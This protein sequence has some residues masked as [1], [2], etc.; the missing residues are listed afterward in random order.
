MR[1][2]LVEG[3]TRHAQADAGGHR[4]GIVQRRDGLADAAPVLADQVVGGQMHVVEHQVDVRA[5]AQAEGGG[6]VSEIGRHAPGVR[7]YR[8][9]RDAGLAFGQDDEELG[10]RTGGDER[11]LPVEHPAVVGLPRL[12][13]EGPD[14]ASVVR[15]GQC[16]AGDQALAEGRQ[17]AGLQCRVAEETQDG[18][19]LQDRDEAD[20][21]GRAR[22]GDL[23]EHRQRMLVRETAA[24]EFRRHEHGA[25][26]GLGQGTDRGGRV[27]VVAIGLHGDGR[28]FPGHEI[29][30]RAE[31]VGIDEIGPGRRAGNAHSSSFKTVNHSTD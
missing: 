6:V 7:R 18:L 23:L 19:G 22:V 16:V 24:T 10:R 1:E 14:V 17:I 27:D 2:G 30:Q 8:E 31:E 28:Y 13:I 3:R 9:R 5:V 25:V 26:A 12:G 15:L 4:A 21:D 20:A 11:F 29:P